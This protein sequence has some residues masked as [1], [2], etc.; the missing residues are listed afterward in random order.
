MFRFI[1]LFI[2]IYIKYLIM[3]NLKTYCVTDV[4]SK[5]LERLNLSLV[6]VGNKKFSNEYIK[7]DNGDNIQ[8]KEKYY[9]ELTF[10]YWFWRNELNK[11]DE[12]I[13]I[14]FCQKED[15]G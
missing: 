10:H 8:K 3:T 13:W 6:G 11:V 2:E 9:S 4:P 5:N 15:F 7:C 14:G 12:K 1:F